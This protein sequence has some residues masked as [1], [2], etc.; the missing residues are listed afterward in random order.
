MR[1]TTMNLWQ[2]EDDVAKTPRLGGMLLLAA[3]V[4]VG[5]AI[6]GDGQAARVVNGVGVAGW[7][8]AFVLL[9]L[10]ARGSK[11][12]PRSAAMVAVLVFVLTVM[13]RFRDLALATVAFS[14]AGAL[15]AVIERD[16]SLQWALLVPAA[17]LPAHVVVNVARSVLAGSTR[18]RTEPPQT[19]ALVPL[20]MVVGAAVGCLVVM[21]VHQHMADREGRQFVRGPN[22]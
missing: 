20:V 1:K 5:A 22:D 13:V 6:V 12:W 15:V 7:L 18:V 17:W 19:A 4:M 9:G 16:R 21:R 3:T 2:H 11:R 14:I 10:S 8:A